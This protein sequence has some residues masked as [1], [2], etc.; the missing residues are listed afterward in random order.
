[1]WKIWESY[2]GTMFINSHFRS[3]VILSG[4]QYQQK[5]YASK[6]LLQLVKS[7]IIMLTQ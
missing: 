5:V 1:M 3:C 6:H 4:N 7:E 2:T